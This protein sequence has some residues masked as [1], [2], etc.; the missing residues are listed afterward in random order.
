MSAAH[1]PAVPQPPADTVPAALSSFVGRDQDL[2]RVRAL[3]GDARVVTLA[4][5]GGAGKTRLAREIAACAAGP[6]L[7]PDGVW[8]AELAPLPPG[9]D[10]VPAVAAVLGVRPPPGAGADA[11]P[12]DTLAT[13]LGTRRLLLVLDNC[14]QV[15]DRCAALAD[16]LLR[17]CPGLAVLATSREALGVEGEVVWPVGGLSHPPARDAAADPAALCAYDAVRL[18]VDRAGAVQPGFALTP[19]NAP[20]VAAVATR[21]DG[22]PLA[23]EL[24]AANVAT[25]GVEALA[26]RLDDAFAVLT[27][28]RRTALPRH[29]TLRALLDWSYDLL[30][31]AEQRLLARLSVFRGAF[32]LEQAE[33]F[34]RRL[35][36]AYRDVRELVEVGAYAAGSDPVADLAITLRPRLDAFLRQSPGDPADA[37]ATWQHLAAVVPPDLVAQLA[38]GVG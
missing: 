10:P 37:E 1:L 2:D 33:H 25:L 19:R 4:G 9:A 16:H 28:G 13:A 5:P 31:P 35:L 34:A 36:A 30:G 18:F 26:A 17:R 21:L 15:V 3:L 22:L 14:E 6:T 23:L 12:A 32:T 24:A 27:R 11:V 20:A 29:R 7:F 38:G 8:W